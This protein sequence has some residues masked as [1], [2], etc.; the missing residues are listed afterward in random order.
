MI[1][2]KNRLTSEVIIEIDSLQEANLRGAAVI[3]F[4]MEWNIYI[5]NGHIRIGCQS[6]PLEKW[7]GFSDD[8]ISSMSGGALE[9]W[10]INRNWIISSCKSITKDDF[11][12][13]HEKT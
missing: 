1:Q 13:A 5:T 8:D 2:I 11:T 9:F 6:H 10:S 4:G 12:P 7:I 3:V